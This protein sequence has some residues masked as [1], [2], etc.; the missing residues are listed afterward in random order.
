MLLEQTN[1]DDLHE[2]GA[3]GKLTQ[4]RRLGFRKMSM[5]LLWS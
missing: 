1:E 2:H 3:L 4:E 5:C